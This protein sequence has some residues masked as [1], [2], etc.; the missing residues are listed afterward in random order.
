MATAKKAPT[1]KAAKEEAPRAQAKASATLPPRPD[2]ELIAL[3]LLFNVGGGPLTLTQD[4]LDA[5]K[6]KSLN[7]TQVSSNETVVSM[8]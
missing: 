1:K 7:V 5:V 8:E 3:A 4:K 2:A 6:G